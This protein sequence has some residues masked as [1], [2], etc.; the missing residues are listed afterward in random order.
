MLFFDKKPHEPGWMAMQFTPEGV[1]LVHVRQVTDSKP[2][3][4]LCALSPSSVVDV[5]VLEKLAKERHLNRYHCSFLLNSGEYQL[6]VVEA[7]NVPATE[8]KTAVRWRIKD[9]LD[10]SV[11]DATVDVLNIPADKNAQARTRSLYAVAARNEVIRKRMVDFD[12][13]KVP[14]SV[15]DIPELAQRNIAH[16]LEDSGRGLALLSFGENGG[17]LTFTFD[18]ELY[19]SRH[20]DVPLSLLNQPGSEQQRHFERITLELQR[21]MDH[22]ERQFSFIAIS[23]LVLAPLPSAVNLEAYLATNLYLPVSTLNLDEIFDFS[24]VSGVGSAQ[25]MQCFLALGAAL[26]TEGMAR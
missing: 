20:I 8:L 22:F 16:L 10:F 25:R 6:L 15:I 1:S 9:M 13:V 4:T 14:V 24:A 7:P 2:L 3:V 11:D 17:L 5:P 19:L 21:S 12:A 23:K 26:R 18:G